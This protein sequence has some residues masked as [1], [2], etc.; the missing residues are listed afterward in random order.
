MR[1][2]KVIAGIPHK[3]PQTFPNQ[4]PYQHSEG[5]RA[6]YLNVMQGSSDFFVWKMRRVQS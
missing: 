5:A 4:L 3:N 6:F 1:T 2:D